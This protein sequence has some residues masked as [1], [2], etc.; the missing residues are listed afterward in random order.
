MAAQ[1][2]GQPE[3]PSAVNGWQAGSVHT[4]VWHS[5]FNGKDGLTPGT[6]HMSLEGIMLMQ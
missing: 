3:G 2:G 5:A 6:T 4:T 1:E